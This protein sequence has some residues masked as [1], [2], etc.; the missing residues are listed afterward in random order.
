MTDDDRNSSSAYWLDEIVPCGQCNGQRCEAC[1]QT[2][3]ARFTTTEDYLSMVATEA[4]AERMVSWRKFDICA[5]ARQSHGAEINKTIAS[6]LNV[7][8]RWVRLWVQLGNT[9]PPESRSILHDPQLY[10]FALKADDPVAAV[11]YA[12]DQEFSPKELKDWLK[13]GG[14]KG[15]D[16]ALTELREL[17]HFELTAEKVALDLVSFASGGYLAYLL[18]EAS[19]CIPDNLPDGDVTTVSIEVTVRGTFSKE[20]NKDD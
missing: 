9:F 2:G 12:I 10:R 11:E 8:T 15:E 19:D 13:G 1:D 14:E 17:W 6:M 20:Q 3:F 16:V 5:A 7:T 4:E 18:N